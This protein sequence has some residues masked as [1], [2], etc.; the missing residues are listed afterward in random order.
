[1]ILDLVVLG[2]TMKLCLSS[3]P[4]YISSQLPINAGSTVTHVD[5]YIKGSTQP[6]EIS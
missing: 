3:G 2:T 4:G 5:P 1:M 6:L